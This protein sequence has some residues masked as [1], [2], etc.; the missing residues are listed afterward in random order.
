MKSGSILFNINR[1]PIWRHTI[2]VWGVKLHTPSLDR[3]L[4]L[5]LHR[6]GV[7]GK[8]DKMFFLKSINKGMHVV[9]VGANIGLYSLFMARC[10]GPEGRVYAFEPEAAMATSLRQS[11]VLN[12]IYWTEVYPVA[13][14]AKSGTGK[15]EYHVLNHGD[16]WMSINSSPKVIDPDAIPIVSLQDTL[17]GKKI[18]LIKIDVQGWEDGVIEGAA[19]LLETNPNLK[20]YFEFMPE[21]MIRAG[22][23]VKRLKEILTTLDLRVDSLSPKG[24]Q[25]DIDIE[26]LAE[27]MTSGAYLNLLASKRVKSS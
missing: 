1:W 3:F 8:T 21:V 16:T 20:I 17:R 27:T 18:D 23:S 5:F 24:N 11:L 14:G 2:K 26:V 25:N 4:Y 13:V 12:E 9:D 19:Q 15:L 6:L 7:M 10:V 22:R